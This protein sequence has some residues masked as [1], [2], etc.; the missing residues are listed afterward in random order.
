M[1][2]VAL[3]IYNV[4]TFYDNLFGFD[5]DDM[6]SGSLKF[7]NAGYESIYS[8]RSFGFIG[9]AGAFWML[10]VGVFSLIK[11]FLKPSW[12]KTKIEQIVKLTFWNYSIAYFMEV[13][14]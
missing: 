10:I 7:I 9:L 1:W 8:I 4:D 6:P 2:V 3:E 11:L 12:L 13:Y 14:V 5:V